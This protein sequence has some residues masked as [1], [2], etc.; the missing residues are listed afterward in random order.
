MPSAGVVGGRWALELHLLLRVLGVIQVIE[1][2]EITDVFSVLEYI[3][4]HPL[5]FFIYLTG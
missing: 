1:E 2:F 4:H 5:V 3:V